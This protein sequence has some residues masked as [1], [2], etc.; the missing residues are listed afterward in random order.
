[1][2]SAL[3]AASNSVEARTIDWPAASRAAEAA[4]RKAQQLGVCVNVAVVDAGGNLAAFVR[5]PGAPLHSIEIAIDKAYTAVS[6][7]LPTGRW[8][9][10]LQ[11][12]SEAVRQGIALRPRFILETAVE[13]DET[14]GEAM[15]MPRGANW[16]YSPNG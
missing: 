13:A 14:V 9:E 11:A 5:M 7:G 12:H 3:N 10:A 6:F 8:G 4:A 15:P 2:N 1:M 16:A